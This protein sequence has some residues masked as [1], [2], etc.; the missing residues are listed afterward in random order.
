[1]LDDCSEALVAAEKNVAEMSAALVREQEEAAA[2]NVLVVALRER[3]GQLEGQAGMVIEDREKLVVEV[4]YLRESLKAGGKVED[5]LTERLDGA[6]A[7]ARRLA[8]LQEEREDLISSLTRE[9]QQLCSDKA[10]A[11]NVQAALQAELQ[12]A[13][14]RLLKVEELLSE[15]QE[16]SQRGRE[17]EEARTKL[18]VELHGLRERLEL[19]ADSL[20]PGT[21]K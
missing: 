4:E 21:D 14:A 15:E 16:V 9:K 1:M 11:G 2:R 20:E 5:G 10:T 6:R 8:V 18:E 3:L 17:A 12:E 13:E 7:E 19:Q